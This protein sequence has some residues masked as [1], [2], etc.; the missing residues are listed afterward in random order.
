[1]PKINVIVPIY[2]VEPYLRRCIDSL[3]AQTY[4]D[5]QIILVDDGSPDKCGQIC[6]EYAEKHNNIRVIHKENGGLSSARNAGIDLSLAESNSEWLTF[7]DSDD[8]L[9]PRYLEIL[10]STAK[11]NDVKISACA[12]RVTDGTKTSD[13]TLTD[14]AVLRDPEAFWCRTRGYAVVAVCKL[15]K[16]ELFDSTRYPL[17]KLHED[18]FTTHK[19]LFSCEKIAYNPSKLYSYYQNNEGITKSTW[20]PKRLDGIEAIESQIEFFKEKGFKTAYK[21][22]FFAL[23]NLI[24]YHLEKELESE[25]CS[26]YAD[27]IKEQRKKLRGLIRKHYLYLPI[28][29]CKDLYIY[30]F[31]RRK[32]LIVPI[33]RLMSFLRCLARKI[34][35]RR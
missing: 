21:K 20:S 28:S 10:Y 30:A 3:L 13:E 29:Y 5:F 6:D 22:S 2:K 26:E 8:Y 1:M 23:A 11:E 17:G 18:E 35:R 27:I 24:R 34:L 19:L 9:H 31:P 4:K 16:K 7:V 32:W 15:Y 33:S 25:N 14:E 12:Y